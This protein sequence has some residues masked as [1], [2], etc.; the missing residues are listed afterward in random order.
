MSMAGRTEERLLEVELAL[1]EE[2]GMTLPPE[3]RFPLRGFARSG[4]VNWRRTGPP[5]HPEG[6]GQAGACCCKVRRLGDVGVVVEVGGA[7]VAAYRRTG[8]VNFS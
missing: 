2:H 4:Q 5:R 6:A 7:A 3:Q 1:L 8:F